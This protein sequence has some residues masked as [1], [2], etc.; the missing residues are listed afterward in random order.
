MGQLGVVVGKHGLK[1]GPVLLRDLVEQSHQPCG[2]RFP[3]LRGQ[4][5][6]AQSLQILVNAEQAEGPGAWRGELRH[7]RQGLLEN[8]PGQ[9]LKAPVRR[10]AHAHAQRP[11]RPPVTILRT[12]LVEPVPVK[13]QQIMKPFRFGIERVM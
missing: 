1:P 12:L 8:L 4:P 9:D 7:G 11:E 3:D 5:V 13:A 10:T 6:A 2:Q